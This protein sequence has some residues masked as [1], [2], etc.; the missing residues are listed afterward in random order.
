MSVSNKVS[1][2]RRGDML[3]FA[4]SGIDVSY[5]N[6]LR[7]TLLSDIS[8]VV[9]RTS[10]YE[11]NKCTIQKNTSRFTNEIIQHRLSCIPICLQNNKMEE[12][13][14][15]YELV[16]DRENKSENMELVTS[17]DF[18][19]RHI[20]TKEWM[21]DHLL[22]TVFPPFT[23]PV[24]SEG[25]NNED[26]IPL[27]RL[28]PKLSA[29][30]P[31]ETLQL[32]CSLSIG[33]AKE[34]A[35][36]NVVG[37]CAHECVVDEAKMQQEWR[38]YAE[39]HKEQGQTEKHN[40]KETETEM[41]NETRNETALESDW[42][43]LHGK[44][45]VVPNAFV[46][47]VKTTGVYSN[48]QLIL[49]GCRVIQRRLEEF[50]QNPQQSMLIEKSSDSF[51]NGY[52]VTLHGQDDTLGN[53]LKYELYSQYFTTQP[54]QLLFVGFKKMHPH[55]ESGVIRLSLADGGSNESTVQTMIVTAAQRAIQVFQQ[56]STFF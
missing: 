10:P 11:E 46:F 56:F 2:I 35:A 45:I 24:A 27:V 47:K 38:L 3:S 1:E 30:I 21:P 32:T 15:Q 9:F 36:F 40:E 54:Q 43:L 44:R 5:V 48:D 17:G 20:H 34:N 23:F 33:T 29:T 52:V 7:R 53:V 41:H 37:T 18:R 14:S 50:I 31:G 42:K 26:F 49:L 16:V 4:W 39:K 51:S 55:D 13:W 25:S 19:L 22:R 6:A 28:R 8:A 12:E